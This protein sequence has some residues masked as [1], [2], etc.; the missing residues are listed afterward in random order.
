MALSSISL[1]ISVVSIN[2]YYNRFTPVP[3]WL[4]R[5]TQGGVVGALVKRTRTKGNVNNGNFIGNHGNI[6]KQE[7]EEKPSEG[8]TEQSDNGVVTWPLALKKIDSILFKV[9]ILISLFLFFVV[10]VGMGVLSSRR[11]PY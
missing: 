4:Q 3:K 6:S 8:N 7:V 5:L 2:K 10:F 1:V 9:I 11:S